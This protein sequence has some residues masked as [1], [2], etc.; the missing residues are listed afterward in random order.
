[1]TTQTFA[2]AVTGEIDT[3]WLV[4]ANTAEEAIDLVFGTVPRAREAWRGELLVWTER[5]YRD[6]YLLGEPMP[7]SWLRL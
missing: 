3:G 5:Y 1:M 7:E 4:E 2:V 6:R